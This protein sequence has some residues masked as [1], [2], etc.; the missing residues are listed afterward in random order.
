MKAFSV[1]IGPPMSQVRESCVKHNSK[2][3]D[4]TVIGYEHL[5]AVKATGILIDTP[6]KYSEVLR[7]LLLNR[8]PELLYLDTD[9]WLIE[10]PKFSGVG[11]G[12][13]SNWAMYSGDNPSIFASML[14]T[15]KG[16][17]QVNQGR[18]ERALALAGAQIINAIHKWEIP[19]FKE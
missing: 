19:W 8:E 5:D 2:L 18:D 3:V 12:S 14:A 11:R 1:H 17:K 9:C 13:R 15:H 16:A 7:L 10:P 4:L 6:L